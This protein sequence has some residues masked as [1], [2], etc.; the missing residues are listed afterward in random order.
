MIED[1]KNMQRA[2]AAAMSDSELA[3]LRWPTEFH[4]AEMQKRRYAQ[5]RKDRA[6]MNKIAEKRLAEY[7]KK[8]SIG[9]AAIEDEDMAALCY[10]LEMN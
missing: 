2:E 4:D 8:G 5:A 7:G 10:A 3:G 9:C 1:A 6:A